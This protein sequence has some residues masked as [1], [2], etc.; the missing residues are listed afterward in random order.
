MKE[1]EGTVLD[2]SCLMF[3]SNLWIGRTHNNSRLP[4][5]LAG[6]LGGT[7]KTGRALN[8]MQ[9]GDENRRMQSLYLSLMD[10]YD[11]KLDS[12]GGTSERLANL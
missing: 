5:V 3:L 2:H 10:R 8:Y 1:G 12:F 4:V 6:G 11:L 7:L 9:A